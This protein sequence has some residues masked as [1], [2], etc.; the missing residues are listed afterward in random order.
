MPLRY[1]DPH[2]E[3]GLRYRA[4]ESFG[5][6]RPGQFV[7]RHVFFRIDPW[8]HRAT[9]GRYPRILGA[10]ATAP[11]TSMGAKS[12][13]SRVC[14]LAYFHDG[15]DPILIA[16]NWAKPKHP[17]WYFN[18]KAYPECQLG[19]QRFVASEVTDSVEYLRLY[20]LAEHVYAGYRDYRMK[21][22][23]IGRQIPIFRLTPLSSATRTSTIG[24]GLGWPR[25]PLEDEA[26]PKMRRALGHDET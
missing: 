9:G 16:S 19:D 10:M 12:G 22:K 13:Q 26:F 11:L 7:S 18:L 21:T 2:N 17:G 15:P 25:I 1:V 5:R 4:V 23:H 20:T 24:P 14:Q 8:L 6:S 3:H